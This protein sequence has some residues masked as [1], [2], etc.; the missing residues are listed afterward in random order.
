MGVAEMEEVE[1]EDC[2]KLLP[3]VHGLEWDA[4][5]GSQAKSHSGCKIGVVVVLMIDGKLPRKEIPEASCSQV[6]LKNFLQRFFPSGGGDVR[7]CVCLRCGIRWPR[8]FCPSRS[9]N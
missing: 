7:V 1:E 4:V 5:I 8:K 6:I 9:L 2:N 3:F